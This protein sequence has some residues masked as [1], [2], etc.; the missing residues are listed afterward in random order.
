MWFQS[1]EIHP[2]QA[3]VVMG[4]L[5]MLAIKEIAHKHGGD[6]MEG[7]EALYRDMKANFQKAK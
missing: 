4:T 7:C 2:T 3:V 5:M 6:P 1:Q